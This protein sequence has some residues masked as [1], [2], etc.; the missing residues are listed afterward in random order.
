MIEYIVVKQAP[1]L[2]IIPPTTEK[3]DH[4]HCARSACGFNI[5]ERDISLY[6]PQS[7]IYMNILRSVAAAAPNE[8]HTNVNSFVCDFVWFP[9]KIG[10]EKYK[11]FD[12][13][14][15]PRIIGCWSL[16]GVYRIISKRQTK[17]WRINPINIFSEF[18]WFCVVQTKSEDLI[19]KVYS[20]RK[21][22]RLI[23]FGALNWT[24]CWCSICFTLYLLGVG[25]SE[26]N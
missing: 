1:Q 10:A 17:A 6:A 9:T 7:H 13:A 4:H 15:R 20:H 25:A 22:E 23:R 26:T 11:W 3:Q 2:K 12:I 21:T 8:N 16:C 18:N 24:I 5:V 14:P 19:G